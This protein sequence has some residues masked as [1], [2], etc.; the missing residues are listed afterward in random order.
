ME[1]SDEETKSLTKKKNVKNTNESKKGGEISTE[2]AKGLAKFTNFYEEQKEVV[3]YAFENNLDEI[4]FDKIPFNKKYTGLDIFSI[5]LDKHWEQSNDFFEQFKYKQIFKFYDEKFIQFNDDIVY[6]LA[7]L[8]KYLFAVGNENIKIY[9]IQNY[10]QLVRY[11]H[12]EKFEFYCCAVNKLSDKHIYLAAGGNKN[13]IFLVNLLNI[14]DRGSYLVGHKN[15]INTLKFCN[16]FKE[17]LLSGSNDC[18]VRLWNV[19][20]KSQIAVFAGPGGH[21]SSV[22]TVAWHSSGDYCASAG[23]DLK[24]LLWDVKR[25][26]DLYM[27]TL[28]KE[29]SNVVKTI[30]KSTPI[31]TCSELHE[32]YIDHVQFFG[33]LLLS[34]SMTGVIYLW[35][36]VLNDESDSFQIINKFVYKTSFVWFLKFYASEET[37][38]LFVGDKGRLF[39]FGLT[40]KFDENLINSE[41][42]Y[43]VKNDNKVI[44][45]LTYSD[46]FKTFICGT[47]SGKIIFLKCDIEKIIKK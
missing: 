8:D 7:V 2:N 9:N 14:N 36:P 43:E 19:K 22:L 28:S 42:Y 4:I 26:V 41:H 35:K 18:S 34:K 17:F 30:L 45:C 11:F 32:N 27:Q 15:D 33:N 16:A 23:F 3:K 24:I 37:L 39:Q 1:F 47:D 46:K 13:A 21:Q 20:T 31:Y 12:C 29:N 25:V 6:D 38:N 44:R 5:N 40:N 10:Y